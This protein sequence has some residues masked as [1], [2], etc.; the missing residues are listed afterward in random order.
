MSWFVGG[1]K[2]GGFGKRLLRRLTADGRIG[3]GVFA[4][5]RFIDHSICGTNPPKWLGVYEIELRPVLESLFPV[6]FE[7]IVDVGA[8][9]GYYAVG[10][11]LKWPGAHVIAFEMTEE[12][13]ELLA[14]VARANG[15]HDRVE[16]RGLCTV[17]DLQEVIKPGVAQL[18][19]MDVEGA[20]DELLDIRQVPA[21]ANCHVIV[22]IHDWEGADIGTRILRDFAPTHRIEE[23]QARRRVFADFEIPSFLPLRWY[24]A[25]SLLA[26][27]YERPLPMRWFYLR[28]KPVDSTAIPARSEHG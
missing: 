12:G 14:G 18:V 4:G 9:E 27:S 16:I 8:A 22:E 20:E 10:S 24:M 5:M 21:L 19:I 23:I 28:P 11:A 25:R 7:Q 2:P 13:R 26:Y 3:A 15:V 6:W 1:L 17:K